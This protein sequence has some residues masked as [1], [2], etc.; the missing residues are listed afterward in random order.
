[1]REYSPEEKKKIDLT[2]ADFD[3]MENLPKKAEEVLSR[4]TETNKDNSEPADT[5]RIEEQEGVTT[6]ETMSEN[7]RG[8]QEI[9]FTDVYTNVEK[10]SSKELFY[11]I[12]AQELPSIGLYFDDDAMPKGVG[13]MSLENHTV[14]KML[15]GTNT[16]FIFNLSHNAFINFLERPGF[17]TSVA[18]EFEKKGLLPKGMAVRA[19]VRDYIDE[20]N[21]CKDENTKAL[22]KKDLDKMGNIEPLSD[23]DIEK[24][25]RDTI[26][27]EYAKSLTNTD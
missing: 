14:V 19:V 7:D 11:R 3:Q 21:K 20:I 15:P 5:N 6:L 22:W 2:G 10:G 25:M 4:E 12:L 16:D 9:S 26:R 27:Q 18:M 17:S 1:M 24:L 13:A 8:P 23:D